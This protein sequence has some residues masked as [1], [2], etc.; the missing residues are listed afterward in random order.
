MPKQQKKIFRIEKQYLFSK[1][2]EFHLKCGKKE[3]L[4]GYE[5]IF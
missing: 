3:E 5:D 4:H 2:N 1:G